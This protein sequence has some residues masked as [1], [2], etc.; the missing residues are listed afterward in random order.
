MRSFG[1][2]REARL[3]L[4]P[5]W[6]DL[7]AGIVAD[8]GANVG[9]WSAAVLRVV[10]EAR[11]LAVEP[12]PEPLRR[13][14]ERFA[15]VPS[16][17]GRR[18]RG[19]RSRRHRRAARHRPQPQLVAARAPRRDGLRLRVHDRVGGRRTGGDADDDAR[20]AARGRGRR[21]A[22]DRRPG[23]RERGPAG[24]ARRPGPDGRGPHRG[25]VRL[26]LRRRRDV[27]RAARAALG[28]RLLAQ[29]AVRSRSAPSAGRARSSGRTPAT[30]AASRPRARR[31]PYGVAATTC[32]RRRR[33]RIHRD[34]AAIRARSR[35]FTPPPATRTAT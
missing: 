10:P 3:D 14:S 2:A 11:V 24:R 20:R 9:D 8:I 32:S 27:P 34:R 31:R 28:A 6:V 22:E 21:P 4:L 7:R 15:G 23:R 16:R 12:A 25:D 17:R 29:R 5:G 13:L 30:A 35:S 1:A 33:A 19:L 26:A 18:P